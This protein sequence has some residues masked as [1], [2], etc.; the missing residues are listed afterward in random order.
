MQHVDV[1][2]HQNVATILMDRP[3][4]RNSLNP[5]LIEDLMTAFSDVHQEKGVTA[6]VLS[7]AGNDF[8]AGLD[9][10][11]MQEIASMPPGDAAPE[12]FN[13][14]NQL[15]RLIEQM[16]RFP[17]PVIAAVD[18]SALGAGLSLALAADIIVASE[19]AA[20]GS[21]AVRRGLVGATTT[22]LLAFRFG[23][24]LAAR[25][26]LTGQPIDAAEACRLGI[27][28]KPVESSQVWVTAVDWANR[29][30][31]APREAIQATKKVL[32]EDIGESLLTQLNAG[33]ATGA[34]VCTTDAAAEGIKAFCEKRP[35]DWSS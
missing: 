33:A 7:G 1:K 13:A 15:T 10:G 35:P 6:V 18:G 26:S 23:S 11:V 4:S 8:C 25:M 30:S 16:L 24:A 22:A 5:T 27:C 21:V 28:D 34:S 32:N 31:Q 20:F 2:I 14:W 9:L 19:S 29:C 17:K 3:D 12:W